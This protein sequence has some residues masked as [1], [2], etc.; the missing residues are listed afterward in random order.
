MWD[1]DRGHSWDFLNSAMNLLYLK[2]RGAF[3]A[4]W[5]AVKFS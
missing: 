2:R 1:R 4:K 3:L 5:A